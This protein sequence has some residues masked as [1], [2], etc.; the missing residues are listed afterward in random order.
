[1]NRKKGKELQKQNKHLIDHKDLERN[2]L[3]EISKEL[4]DD[5]TKKTKKGNR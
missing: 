1:M 3:T 2:L 4:A 5:Q